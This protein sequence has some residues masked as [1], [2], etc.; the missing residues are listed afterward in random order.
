V[1]AS[2]WYEQVNPWVG[3][4][5]AAAAVVEHSSGRTTVGTNWHPYWS[6]WGGNKSVKT[7]K[8]SVV[9]KKAGIGLAVLSAGLDFADWAEGDLPT[10]HLGTN[11][12][13]DVVSVSSP[14][15]AAAGLAYW[16]LEEW[17]PGGAKGAAN[18]Y[19]GVM[20]QLQTI[21]PNYSPIPLT[22]EPMAFHPKRQVP[23]VVPGRKR[24]K[25]TDGTI[26]LYDIPL[27]A[28]KI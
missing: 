14:E 19:I 26:D 8:V 10:W 28:G 3:R 5:G 12:T 23:R 6:G 11:L 17:Y 13:M 1:T 24:P 21:N 16:G 25:S 7:L 20:Q 4:A 2:R 27:D 18:D 15:G 9:A 22:M